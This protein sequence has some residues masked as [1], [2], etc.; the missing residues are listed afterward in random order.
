[1]EEYIALAR[2]TRLCASSIRNT[3]SPKSSELS[4]KYSFCADYFDVAVKALENML[5]VTGK[6]VFDGDIMTKGVVVRH[7]IL[8]SH[9]DDSIDILRELYERFG[10]DSFLLSLMSQ[11]TPTEKCRDFPEINRRVTSIEYK[12][13]CECFEK[14]GFTGYIQERSSAVEDYIPNFEDKGEFII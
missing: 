14:L 12:R 11:F 2:S 10:N 9:K 5:N 3:Y 6:P 8:P 13:V 7:L 1:M 4:K